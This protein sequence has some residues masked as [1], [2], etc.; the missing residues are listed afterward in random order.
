ME[1]NLNNILK[2]KGK[3]IKNEQ[4]NRHNGDKNDK[5]NEPNLINERHRTNTLNI[6][7]TE[8]NNLKHRQQV[9]QRDFYNEKIINQKKNKK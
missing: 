3:T 7:I 8:N 5:Y 2:F 6:E 9:Y 4:L 1:N